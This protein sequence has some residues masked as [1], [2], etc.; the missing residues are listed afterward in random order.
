M[1][2]ETMKQFRCSRAGQEALLYSLSLPG[3]H[4][5]VFIFL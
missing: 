1:M 4:L 2:L 5:S 3:L